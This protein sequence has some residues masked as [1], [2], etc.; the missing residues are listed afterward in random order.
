MKQHYLY[1]RIPLLAAVMT[2]L[3]IAAFPAFAED[4]ITS[5]I[6]LE[7]QVGTLEQVI[8]LGEYITAVY[9]F[10]I[11]AIAVVAVGMI[12]FGGAQWALAAGN[13]EKVNEAK[14]RITNALL[15]LV[16]ALLSY[17][18]MS[19]ISDGMVIFGNICPTGIEFTASG[20][21]TTSDWT[22]C[23]G[24]AE[25]ACTS[26]SYCVGGCECVNV[27]EGLTVCR[28]T[29]TN[30]NGE[31]A[32]CQRDENCIEPMTCAGGSPSAPGVC[33]TATS[34]TLCASEA[35]C[36]T[37]FVCEGDPSKKCLT[38]NNRSEGAYCTSD[39]VCKS[40]ICN[41]VENFCI[42][43]DGS[44]S[45]PCVNSSDCISGFKCVSSSCTPKAEGD[46]CDG[47]TDCYGGD[48]PLMYCSF[49]WANECFDG[50]PGDECTADYQCQ[51]P[52]RG[53]T[54]DKCDDCTPGTTWDG[55]QH[56]CV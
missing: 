12:M 51:G 7:V 4:C 15:G 17:T 1:K 38:Q 13:S 23:P 19:I 21:G 11:Q 26:V 24:G 20:D 22:E 32:A 44:D 40:G 50:S 16:L 35:D 6:K 31:G 56:K 52:G 46:S 37:G 54:D 30:T 43:G 41:T 48:S 9:T 49:E 2:G 5:P 45:L 18:I 27:G 39:S 8:S 29:G 10:L 14:S 28:P 3:F 47:D 34:G 25:S 53:C 42:T 55:S 36:E 33:T